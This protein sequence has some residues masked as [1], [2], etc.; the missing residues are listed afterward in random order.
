M[1]G[2]GNFML[3]GT[4]Y[5]FR[6]SSGQTADGN[7]T[8]VH[9][10][11][12]PGART[13]SVDLDGVLSFEARAPRFEGAVTLASPAGQRA[14]GNAAPPPWRISSPR[15]RPITRRRGSSRSK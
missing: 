13:L 7:G 9:L 11:I 5:P 6:V 4:R 8:R 2:D 1:R 15:S 10:N 12:D 3:S 14:G